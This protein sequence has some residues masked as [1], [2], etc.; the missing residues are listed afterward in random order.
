M[1]KKS[2]NKK[3]RK[4]PKPPLSY[5]DKAI[6]FLVMALFIVLILF[7]LFGYLYIQKSIAYRDPSVVAYTEHL[8]S[9]WGTIFL[10][11]TILSGIPVVE[12]YESKIPIFGNP[13]ITY[14]R[15]PW[16]KDFFPLLDPRRKTV[17][18]SPA[19]KNIRRSLIK[20][21]FAV[22]LLLLIFSP[23][24]LSGRDCLC[25]DN[26]IPRYNA[27]N[28]KIRSY[29][30]ENFSHLT[31]WAGF[32]YRHHSSVRWRYGITI[33]MTDGKEIHFSDSDFNRSGANNN[34]ISLDKMTQI[35]SLFPVEDITIKGQENVDKVS[36][37]IGL[38]DRQTQ[39]LRD[40]FDL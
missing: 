15:E 2:K 4:I 1:R 39:M 12:A 21:W 22:F 18:T 24:G 35:K 31:L 5:R 19:K 32:Q 3:K 25:R 17:Y 33:E 30:E 34:D 11:Y 40:L 36:D 7:L 16:P 26:S 8:S 13:K 6:Y 10:L 20:V 27:V 29:S 38:N 9:L 23:L 28:Q 14:G 37:D